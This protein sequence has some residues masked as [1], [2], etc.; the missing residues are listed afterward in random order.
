ML[1]YFEGGFGE[2]F[3]KYS[4]AL[5]LLPL[6]YLPNLVI[7]EFWSSY[8]AQIALASMIIL[9]WFFALHGYAK[10][11][12][13]Q[14]AKEAL[15]YVLSL[16]VVVSVLFAAYNVQT[17]FAVPLS[18]ELRGDARSNKD[19]GSRS[20]SKHLRDRLRL[21]RLHCADCAL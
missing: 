11:L 4:I 17:Y 19:G 6:T 1:P 2:R 14:I 20:S 13:D 7:V 21:A 18:V 8:R 9:F 12:H 10:S 15:I 5:S 3:S 16:F